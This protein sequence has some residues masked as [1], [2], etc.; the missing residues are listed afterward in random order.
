M[1]TLSD[2]II[3][4]FQSSVL[5][6][7][8]NVKARTIRTKH[9]YAHILAQLLR[10]SGTFLPLPRKKKKGN[11]LFYV[12]LVGNSFTTCQWI[13]LY[14]HVTSQI[15][16]GQK[17]DYPTFTMKV[18]KKPFI[19]EKKYSSINTIHSFIRKTSHRMVKITICC[20]RLHTK[21]SIALEVTGLQGCRYS[22]YREY[23]R[24]YYSRIYSRVV[25]LRRV[26]FAQYSHNTR[27]IFANIILVREF[28]RTILEFL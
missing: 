21:R 24:E 5:N 25:F 7:L 4:Y 16:T 12:K 8:L 19:Y 27:S 11:S 2:S 13:K 15:N 17:Q 3:G 1:N 6:Y 28:P 10:A 18:M 9:Q 22:E 26:I 20:C 23:T 14:Y